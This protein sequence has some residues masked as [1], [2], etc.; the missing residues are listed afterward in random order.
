MTRTIDILHR[1]SKTYTIHEF[2]LQT[3]TKWVVRGIT[4]KK[5]DLMKVTKCD[6]ENEVVFRKVTNRAKVPEPALFDG[7]ED[8]SG[9][10]TN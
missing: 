6:D 1:P 9:F 3:A 7:E 2:V 10:T 5:N 4:E 8:I